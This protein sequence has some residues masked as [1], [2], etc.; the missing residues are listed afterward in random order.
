MMHRGGIVQVRG[1]V[2]D[3]RRDCRDRPRLPV[4]RCS[5][6]RGPTAGPPV[7]QINAIMTVFEQFARQ[8]SSVGSAITRDQI[9]DPELRRQSASLNRRTPSVATCLPAGMRVDNDGVAA[10]EHADG[11]AGNGWQAEWVTGVIAPITPNGARSMTA[12][13]WS[14]LKH[15]GFQKLDSGCLLAQAFSKLFNFVL[16][17]ADLRLFAFPSSPS[18]SQLSIEI[19]RMHVDHPFAVLP[20]NGRRILFRMQRCA[21][22]TAESASS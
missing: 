13:P 14:P 21:A 3:D 12:K 22:V 5:A 2:N 20:A 11:V 17:T 19:R 15:F 9:V 8:L 10:G 16:G 18:S 6:P 1:L 7:T 4:C